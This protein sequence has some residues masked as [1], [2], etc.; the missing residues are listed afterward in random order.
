MTLTPLLALLTEVGNIIMKIEKHAILDTNT[1]LPIDP[2]NLV[3]QALETEPPPQTKEELEEA[4]RNILQG[5]QI[6]ALIEYSSILNE[7]NNNLAEKVFDPNDPRFQPTS[8]AVSKHETA[9]E[10]TPPL[11]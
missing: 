10:R 6:D 11:S 9:L 5:L 1:N 7:F 8:R 2:L 3:K 4:L